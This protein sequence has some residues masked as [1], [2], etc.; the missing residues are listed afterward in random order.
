MI[1]P[2][3]RSAE[4][5]H[6]ALDASGKSGAYR[7]HRRYRKARAGKPAAGFS[8]A[9]NDWL[10]KFQSVEAVS[11]HFQQFVDGSKIV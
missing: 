11:L 5:N 7:H 8:F 2:E 4:P 9:P 10:K 1:S 3:C 6:I